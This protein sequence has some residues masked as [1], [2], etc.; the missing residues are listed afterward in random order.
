[1]F[2]MGPDW[3]SPARASFRPVVDVRN[4]WVK[5]RRD[6]ASAWTNC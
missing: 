5:R 4:T 3:K 2:L 1:M 6:A